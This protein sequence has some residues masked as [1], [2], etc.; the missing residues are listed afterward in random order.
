MREYAFVVGADRRDTC[1]K[2]KNTGAI[3]VGIVTGL[4]GTRSNFMGVT[5]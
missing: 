3:M 4:T 1:R 2:R 5:R